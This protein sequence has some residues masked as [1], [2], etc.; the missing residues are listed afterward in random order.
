MS[1]RHLNLLSLKKKYLK[2]LDESTSLKLKNFIL[3]NLLDIK[4]LKD[5]YSNNNTLSFDN[6]I[7]KDN[8]IISQSDVGF[9]NMICNGSKTFFVDF[10]YAG[11]DD[12]FKLFSDIIL[13]P[14]Y[15]LP[16]EFINLLDYY[17]D[18]YIYINNFQK[19]R[20]ILMLEL[21]RLKWSVIILNPIFKSQDL[22]IS[23][24]NK[25]VNNKLKKSINYLKESSERIKKIKERYC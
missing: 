22:D 18:K 11:W 15:N 24:F 7:A 5:L 19:F 9:H 8:R 14:D 21:Y 2:Q 20:L 23:E 6:E 12:P 17:V 4:N 13:Q 1:K 25:F 3:K 10:E 16:L